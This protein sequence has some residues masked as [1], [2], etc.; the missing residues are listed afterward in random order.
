MLGLRRSSYNS[1]NTKYGKINISNL[2]KVIFLHSF[3]HKTKFTQMITDYAMLH[4]CL[5]QC[6]RHFVYE[7]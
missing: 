5:L 4:S 6:T 2:T 3:N 1:V 7:G